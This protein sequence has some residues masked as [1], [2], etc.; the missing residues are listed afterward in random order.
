MPSMQSVRRRPAGR[1]FPLYAAGLCLSVLTSG[2]LLARGA[3]AP[4]QPAAKPQAPEWAYP[5]TATRTQV[6]P[7]PDFRRPSTH[8]KTPI[9]LFDG[10]S[11]IGTAVVPGSASFD[12]ASGRYTITSAGYNIWYYRD[13]FRFL[14]KRM[15]GDVS[16]AADIAY[17]DPN[18]YGD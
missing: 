6:P 8:Y 7:P 13:E 12:A 16:L 10:Q 3:S 11:D 14:W 2:V 18:G 17:P 1:A 15:S 4:A 9:G 5:G